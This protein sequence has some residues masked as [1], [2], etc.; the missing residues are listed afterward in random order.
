[1]SQ[2]KSEAH[3]QAACYDWYMKNMPQDEWGR[4]IG[5][6]NNPPNISQLISMGLRPGISDFLYYPTY[7][8][9]CPGIIRIGERRYNMIIAPIWIELKIKGK[10][11]NENQLKFQ[12]MVEGWGHSYYLVTEDLTI[13]INL[14]LKLRHL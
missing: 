2:W 11:Q 9:G 10:K 14:I 1:M 13:F 8:T 6:Y 4:L 3:F 5:I 7:P 12:P